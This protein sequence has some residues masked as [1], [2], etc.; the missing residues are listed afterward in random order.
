[1]LITLRSLRNFLIRRLLFSFI[2]IIAI[3]GITFTITHLA[4]GGPL[5]YYLASNPN[6]RYDPIFM[7]TMI[8]RMGLDKPTH[9]QYYLWLKNFIVGDFGWSFTSGAQISTLIFSRLPITLIMTISANVFSFIIAVPLG[10]ITAI[11]QYTK[12]DNVIMLLCLF[13]VSVPTFWFGLILIYLFSLQSGLLPVTG[14]HTFGMKFNNVFSEMWDL[15]RHLILP[16]I[17]LSITQIAVILRL[18]RSSLLEVL[19][20]D[21]IMTARSKGLSEQIVLFKHALRNALLPVVTVFGMSMSFMLAGSVIV[22]SIF[23][24][25]GMGRLILMA[26]VQRD[27]PLIMATST[28]MSILVV[29][30]NLITDICYALLD[31]RVTYQ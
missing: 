29:I 7:E 6:L 30:G 11:K 10:V 26:T 27:Y 3:S 22:E 18:T 28:M 21:Y 15:I 13:G 5:D 4:P 20:L 8:R 1:M 31:P 17:S 2:T 25:P 14:I 16:V 19:G 9:V 23:A 12:V 24:L